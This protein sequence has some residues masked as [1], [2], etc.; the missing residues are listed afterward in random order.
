MDPEHHLN[1]EEFNPTRWD[2]SM[3]NSN[4]HLLGQNPK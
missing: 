2:V 4:Q 3:D 1:P